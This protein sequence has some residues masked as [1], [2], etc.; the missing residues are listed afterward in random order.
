MLSCG[1]L[2]HDP[3]G[4]GAAVAIL[5]AELPCRDGMLKCALTSVPC[6]RVTRGHGCVTAMLSRGVLVHDPSG[7]GAAVAVLAAELPCR[8]GMLTNRTLERAK[9]VHQCDGVMSHTMS[10]V[11][12]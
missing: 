6:R 1:V 12:R 8:D 2:V 3:S 10:P 11:R 9:T 5:A 7:L 4:L